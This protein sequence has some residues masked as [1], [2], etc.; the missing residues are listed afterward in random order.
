MMMTTFVST[1]PP[2]SLTA[3]STETTPISL[4]FDFTGAAAEPTTSDVVGDVAVDVARDVN[5]GAGR[6]RIVALGDS[7]EA[8]RL[9]GMVK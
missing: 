7:R 6:A 5:M 1:E 3:S 8:S 9:A 4:E 2:F